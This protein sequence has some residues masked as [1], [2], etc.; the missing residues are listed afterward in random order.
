MSESIKPFLDWL[1]AG[2]TAGIF[3][4][5]FFAG[6]LFQ[7]IKGMERAINGNEDFRKAIVRIDAETSEWHNQ[8][9]NLSKQLDGLQRDFRETMTEI[10]GKIGRIEGKIG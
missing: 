7:R 1:I 4:G 9:V 6:K 3:T 8:L 5:V 2:N 10:S